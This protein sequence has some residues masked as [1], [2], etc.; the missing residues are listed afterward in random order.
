MPCIISAIWGEILANLRENWLFGNFWCKNT[1]D[2]RSKKSKIM[3]D[4]IGVFW[5]KPYS[6]FKNQ[7][8]LQI[9]PVILGNFLTFL[10]DNLKTTLDYRCLEALCHYGGLTVFI[11]VI[12]FLLV[13][14]LRQLINFQTSSV[15]T[16]YNLKIFD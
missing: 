12:L 9:S 7:Y 4:I 3:L 16:L 15:H 10:P 2:Y 11:L 14:D 6:F 13:F 1:L 8:V 5:G